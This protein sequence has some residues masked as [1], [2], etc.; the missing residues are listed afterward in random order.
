MTSHLNSSPFVSSLY[1]SSHLNSFL[2]WCHL[3]SFSAFSVNVQS[4][5]FSLI[6]S[7]LLSSVFVLDLSSL[8]FSFHLSCSPVISS[9]HVSAFHSF[10]FSSPLSIFV[11]SSVLFS[12]LSYPLVSSLCICF[13]LVSFHLFY[14]SHHFSSHLLFLLSSSSFFCCFF[15]STCLFSCLLIISLIPFLSWCEILS[16]L[17]SSS[18]VIFSWLF[19]SHLICSFIFSSRLF[20][21]V[22]VSSH[23]ISSHLI[24]YCLD[25]SLL[26][27]SHPICSSHLF[28]S[29]CLLSSMSRLVSSLL[30]SS[31]LL[32]FSNERAG[33]SRWRPV[34]Q[35]ARHGNCATLD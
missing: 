9:F 35:Q 23:L 8:L 13:C 33:G 28:Y 29:H 25:L 21:S 16:H 32:F 34:D 27:S 24:Y 14:S 6:F 11:I 31:F 30:F 19:S 1:F 22:F 12:H 3:I 15:V 20:S 4:V 17:F 5:C 26:V 2:S 7:L 10:L 18:L